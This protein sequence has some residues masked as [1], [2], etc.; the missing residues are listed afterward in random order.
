M[1]TVNRFQVK[2]GVTIGDRILVL[3]PDGKVRRAT[4]TGNVTRLFTIPA[5]VCIL[6]LTVSGKIAQTGPWKFRFWPNSGGK[7]SNLLSDTYSPYRLVVK[8]NGKRH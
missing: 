7:N 4:V 1:S 8:R 3:C 5:R 6:G 2:T